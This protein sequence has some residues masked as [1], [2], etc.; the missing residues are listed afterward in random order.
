LVVVDY[1]DEILSSRKDDDDYK[2]GGEI[3]TGLMQ[4][5]VDFNAL[6]WTASQ[7]NRWEPT[8]PGDVIRGNNIADSS[9]K[10]W[11]ADG[12]IT[13]TQ[14]PE[15]YDRGEARLWIDKVRRGVKNMLIPI[16]VDFD[17]AY[18]RQDPT[19]EAGT[20]TQFCGSKQKE[21]RS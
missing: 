10:R 19:R 20:L 17:R 14:T 1:M 6:I 11:K 18:M 2:G 5:G 4:M 13:L 9:R 16:K 21:V 15:E 12:L 3:A 7:V 8:F